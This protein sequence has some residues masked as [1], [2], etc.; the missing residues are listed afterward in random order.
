M[1]LWTKSTHPEGQR[2]QTRPYRR[3]LLGQVQS[4]VNI[5]LALPQDYP[6]NRKG[7]LTSLYMPIGTTVAGPSSKPAQVNQYPSSGYMGHGRYAQSSSMNM[8]HMAYSLPDPRSQ[9]SPFESHLA[10]QYPVMPTQGLMYPM[11]SMGHYPGQPPGN[12][13][14]GIPYPPTYSSYGMTQH[15]GT[16]QQGNS[17]Y[18]SYVANP[19]MQ[20]VGSGQPPAYGNGYYAQNY[21]PHYGHATH[22]LPGQMQSRTPARQ[23]PRGPPLMKIDPKGDRGGGLEQEYDVSKTIVDGSNPSRLAQAPTMAGTFTRLI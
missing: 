21:A 3:M 23:G 7:S 5:P 6:A 16:A 9:P 15:P 17:H 13:P 10:N 14:F 22:P 11:Q 20:S 2:A 12:I 18:P 1:C 8:S 19:S 4:P